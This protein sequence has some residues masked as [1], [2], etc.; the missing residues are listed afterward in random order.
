MPMNHND[1]PWLAHRRKLFMRPDAERYLRPDAERWLQPNRRLFVGP[2]ADEVK[3]NADQPRVPAGQP[4]GGQWTDDGG[5]SHRDGLMRLAG[6][7]PTNDTPEVPKER[8]P[9]ARLRNRIARA[10]ARQRGSAGLVLDA[11]E[12][13]YEHRAEIG[14]YF[15]P[16]KSLEQLQRDV[17][18]PAAG[19]DIHHIVERNSVKA[20]GSQDHLIDAPDNLVRIPRWKHWELNRWY[21]TQSADFEWNSPREFLRKLDWGERRRIGMDAMRRIGVLK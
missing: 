5:G 14:S 4:D 19:Y 18:T 17:S 11:A 15:D 21:A 1:P 6:E 8:P 9:T 12:W 20:D 16:P 7:I 2:Q 10:L 13:L 3:Y